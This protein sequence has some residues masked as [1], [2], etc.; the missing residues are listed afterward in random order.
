MHAIKPVLFMMRVMNYLGSIQFK[1]SVLYLTRWTISGF[2]RRIFHS[3]VDPSA[4]IFNSFKYF[5][6]G[7]ISCC[8]KADAWFTCKF[9]TFP[10]SEVRCYSSYESLKSKDCG[11]WHFMPWSQ[12]LVLSSDTSELCK[13]ITEM[14]S[15]FHCVVC[16]SVSEVEGW[17]SGVVLYLKCQ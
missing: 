2:L 7:Q 11:T 8:L 12:H 17:V 3:A 5:L 15:N 1:K 13:A 10:Q 4:Y 9:L 6:N 14:V 16:S